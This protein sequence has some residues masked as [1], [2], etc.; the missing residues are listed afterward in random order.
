MGAKAA[1]DWVEN[2]F[3]SFEPG[4]YRFDVEESIENGDC[5][6]MTVHQAARGR[7]SGVVVEIRTYHAVHASSRAADTPVRRGQSRAARSPAGR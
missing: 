1:G 2:W 6:F 3:S 7:A 4:S 5:V